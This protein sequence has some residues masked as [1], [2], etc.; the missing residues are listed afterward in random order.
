MHL[1]SRI[2]NSLKEIAKALNKHPL[3]TAYHW[4]NSFISQDLDIEVPDIQKFGIDERALCQRN[5]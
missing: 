1:S 2:N 4:V 3:R 5:N